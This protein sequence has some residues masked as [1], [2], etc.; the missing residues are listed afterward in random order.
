MS[1]AME[2]AMEMWDRGLSTVP[3]KVVCSGHIDDYAIKRFIKQ[4]GEKNTCD[5]CG[6]ERLAVQLEDLMFFVTDAL[7][8]FY[9]DPANFM[10]YVSAEGGYLGE[11]SDAWE[12]LENLGLE[13]ADD[14]LNDDMYNS[15]DFS[16]GWSEEYGNARDYHSENWTN[17]KHVVKNESR[18]L[19][20][21]NRSFMAGGHAFSAKGFLKEIG[22]LILSQKMMTILPKGIS[23]FRCRQHT[24]RN[25]VTEVKHICAPEN[26][27]VKL[28]NRMSPAGISMFY[29]AFK[30]ATAKVETVDSSDASK[31]F[32]TMTEFRTKSELNL[33]DLSKVP[34][35]P[36]AFDQGK[37]NIYY[38]I[39]FLYDFV[40]DFTKPIL[41]DGKEHVEYVPT[42]IVTE[43]FRFKLGKTFKRQI[44]GI[45]YPS[46]KNKK[47]NACVLFMDHYE[48]IDQLEFVV[49]S[50]KT[51]ATL[52][53]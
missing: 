51:K 31:P 44:D 22:K 28:P 33:I 11:V 5:Y 30:S 19:F 1:G 32:Y 53:L 35:L 16:N 36:S 9:T 21:A 29:G 52:T 50:L 6:K 10:P 41:R 13:V 42:Q 7:S 49:P 2:E 23:I 34:L 3:D 8:H 45:I 46:S 24:T 38:L 14:E 20:T 17:F 40:D 39:D 4:N 37:W 12:L 26:H 15:F 25:E 18:F 43:Y 48:S 27:F 47:S